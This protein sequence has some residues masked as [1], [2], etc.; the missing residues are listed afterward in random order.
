[1]T[2]KDK[3]PAGERERAVKYESFREGYN[4]CYVSPKDA[5]YA[6][7]DTGAEAARREERKRCAEIASKM[8]DSAGDVLAKGH[9]DDAAVQYDT[10]NEIFEAIEELEER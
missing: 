8:R 4:D 1:M 7:Y 3:T 5:W 6:G 2:D 9:D 10:A